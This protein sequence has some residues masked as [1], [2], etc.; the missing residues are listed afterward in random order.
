MQ[1]STSNTADEILA[2]RQELSLQVQERYC[3]R[4]PGF[5]TRYREGVT[6]EF[7]ADITRQLGALGSALRTEIRAL[8][9]DYIRWQSDVRS[10]RQGGGVE[11]VEQ[12][13]CLEEVLTTR[14]AASSEP[15]G[16]YLE[17]ARGQ[18]GVAYEEPGGYKALSASARHYLTLVLA[19]ERAQ[20]VAFINDL[21]GQGSSVE[22][23]YLEVLEPVQHEVGR[24][25]Q[26][27][28]LS[29][30][31]EH[32]ATAVGQLT[33]AQL[34][35]HVMRAPRGAPKL[36]A[37]CVAGELHELGARMVADFFEMDGWNTTYLG[38]NTPK[39]GLLQLMLHNVPD[40]LALSVTNSFQVAE[41]ASIIDAVRAEPTLRSVKI[42]V[43]G[44]PF[45]IS[46]DLSARVG[47]DAFAT[48]ARAGVQAG[49]AL[50]DG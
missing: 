40:V 49:R 16:S 44:R 24:L 30:A 13:E 2:H 1:A 47:A 35:P 14:Y 50:L 37:T 36:L 34:Y 42:L 3:A 8:F 11:L 41:V 10:N 18:V 9:D 29:V 32:L 17:S 46:A 12:L 43:G 39:A 45:R 7:A 38:A 4:N 20:A 25:W 19:G 31:Q 48:D 33:V 15:I 5:R 6:A 22:D 26:T 23:A 21:V 28:V 27:N